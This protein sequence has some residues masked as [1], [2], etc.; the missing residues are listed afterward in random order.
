MPV[1]T[2]PTHKFTHALGSPGLRDLQKLRSNE[3][4][5]IS[6]GGKKKIS[7]CN[8]HIQ[9]GRP[10]RA[11]SLDDGTTNVLLHLVGWADEDIPAP[12]T[13]GKWMEIF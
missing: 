10:S 13:I 12:L 9:N 1:I 2:V 4:N 8:R 11:S 7:Q 3:A 6:W 5:F